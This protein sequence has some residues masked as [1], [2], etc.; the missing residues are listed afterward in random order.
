MREFTLRNKATRP[1]LTLTPA[2]L[3]KLLEARPESAQLTLEKYR[4]DYKTL[5]GKVVGVDYDQQQALLKRAGSGEHGMWASPYLKLPS[6]IYRIM[7]VFQDGY[8]N[9]TP[10]A[11]MCEDL[12]MAEAFYSLLDV[13]LP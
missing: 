7:S 3:Q 6:P 4:R 12:E 8:L 10:S 1:I 11:S 9:R 13:H 2:M 5:T